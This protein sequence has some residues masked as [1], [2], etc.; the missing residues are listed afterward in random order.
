MTFSTLYDR[1]QEKEPKISTRWLRDQ[2]IDITPITSVKEQ[3]TSLLD[4]ESIRGF[5]IEGPLEPP[6]PLGANESLIVL[7][8][9]LDKEW[10]RFVYTKELMHTFDTEEEK[11]DTEEKFDIQ[12]EKL[13]D[14]AAPISPQWKAEI[15]AFWRALAVLCPENY[16]CEAKAMI[17]KD[18][19][20]VSSVAARLKIPSSR[21]EFLFRDD[22]LG[23]LE[24]IK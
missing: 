6:V 2:V 18:E 15:T 1:V 17:D 20:S 13:G 9:S 16:R 8:R 4:G 10:R 23:I 5:Y 21:A 24:N 22:Y 11:T 7:K 3:W 14:P 19:L 12:I